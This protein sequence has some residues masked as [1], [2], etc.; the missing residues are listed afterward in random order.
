MA[1]LSDKDL[2]HLRTFSPH[3][4]AELIDAIMT[5]AATQQRTCYSNA[6]YDLALAKL[7]KG[8]YGLIDFQPLETAFT[9]VWYRNKS[10][11]LGLS[12]SESVVMLVWEADCKNA[13]DALT[14]MSLWEL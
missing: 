3:K 11:L 1:Q 8:G 6:Q 14:L 4:K 2:Q 12:K 10:R 13:S 9:T 5:R 7:R